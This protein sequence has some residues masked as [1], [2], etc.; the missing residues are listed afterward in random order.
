[1][2]HLDAVARENPWQQYEQ[3]GDDRQMPTRISYAMDTASE[4]SK[5]YRIIHQTILIY[6]G[7]RGRVT[8]NRLFDNYM[9][10]RA[11]YETLPISV[12]IN[13]EEGPTL[14]HILFFQ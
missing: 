13:E 7:S 10:Y 9:R 5:L 6:C 12:T 8:Q 2:V 14:P 3:E 1:M 11:L 4:V